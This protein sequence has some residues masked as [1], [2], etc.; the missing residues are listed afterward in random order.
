MKGKSFNPPAT[1][2]RS[3]HMPVK[4]EVTPKLSNISTMNSMKRKDSVLR[5]L[6]ANRWSASQT[7]QPQPRKR[8]SNLLSKRGK[9][10]RKSEKTSKTNLIKKRR[11]WKT[12]NL[13]FKFH[14]NLKNLY[15]KLPTKKWIKSMIIW[16]TLTTRYTSSKPKLTN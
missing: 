3:E 14:L 2:A 6:R 9:K 4:L 10:L 11:K 8:Q 16:S 12:N 7:T 1:Q 5:R 13:L 15:R